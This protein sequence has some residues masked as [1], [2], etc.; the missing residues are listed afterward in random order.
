M[1]LYTIEHASASF[2]WV[3]VNLKRRRGLEHI[4]SISFWK[5]FMLFQSIYREKCCHI[6]G[7]SG[8]RPEKESRFKQIINTNSKSNIYWYFCRYFG[9]NWLDELFFPA[10]IRLLM[11]IRLN[12]MHWAWIQTRTKLSMLP[13]TVGFLPEA[14]TVWFPEFSNLP[15]QTLST[16]FLYVWFRMPAVRVHDLRAN[17]YR[18]I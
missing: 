15:K 13:M 7:I 9:T 3:R 12:G 11:P 2:C 5:A 16:V 10:V 4:A 6:C 18:T 1:K 17:R 14:Y 8:W